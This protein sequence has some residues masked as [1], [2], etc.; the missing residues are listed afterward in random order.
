MLKK[1]IDWIDERIKIREVIESNLTGYM[2]PTNLNFWYSMGSVL[3]AML[4][5]QFITGILLLIYYVPDVDKAFESVTYITNEVPFG[6]LIRRVH[7]MATN[8]FIAV[9]FLLIF[10][11]SCSTS[12]L[13]EEN[14]HI[15]PSG[16]DERRGRKDSLRPP[17]CLRGPKGNILF[18]RNPFYICLFLPKA[19][20]PT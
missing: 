10:R 5:I 7:A 1:I 13:Y 8:I 2:V 18:P 6:W 9:L 14:R 19:L 11:V 15:L 12:V 16:N 4:F 20:F 3:L 17:F